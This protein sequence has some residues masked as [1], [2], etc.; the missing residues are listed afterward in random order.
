MAGAVTQDGSQRWQTVRLRGCLQ[1]LG[2]LVALGATS[3]G[4]AAAAEIWAGHQVVRGKRTLPLFGDV[5]TR[6]DS[7][8]LA[9][10][11]R[12]GAHVELVQ[13]ACRVDFEPVL[14]VSV[15][16]HPATLARLP[17]TRLTLRTLGDTWSAA[18]WPAGW[19]IEDVDQDGQPGATIEVD[20][21]LC[22]GDLYVASSTLSAAQGSLSG[23]DW[24]G[25]LE[26]VVEERVLG[27]SSWCLRQASSD[28]NEVQRGDVIYRQVAD[29]ATCDTL[30]AQPWPVHVHAPSEPGNGPTSAAE[31]P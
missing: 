18:P 3:D 19:D 28:R 1:A 30:N 2:V 23:T 27:A 24:V 5:A 14:G 31:V 6:T 29:S 8:L 22:G 11:H 20:G 17:A 4:A 13:R 7:F 10:V 25:R 9:E 16:L 15:R 26:V 21:P 12:E